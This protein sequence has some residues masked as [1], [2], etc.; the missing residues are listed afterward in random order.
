MI[1]SPDIRR[2]PALE[3]SSSWIL[4]EVYANSEENKPLV[5]ESDYSE[6]VR[7]NS[8]D[9]IFAQ[10]LGNWIKLDEFS[11]QLIISR[12]KYYLIKLVNNFSYN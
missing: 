4:Y 1:T 10:I 6:L 12:S 3:S 11:Y 9:A 2:L 7:D 5:H 8:P